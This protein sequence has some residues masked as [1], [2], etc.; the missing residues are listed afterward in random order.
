MAMYI[1]MALAI[2]LGC[3][4]GCGFYTTSTVQPLYTEDTLT[5]EPALVGTWIEVDPVFGEE[6]RPA[7]TFRELAG[8]AYELTVER[9]QERV[10]FEA[11]LVRL[12]KWLYMDLFPQEVAVTPRDH[13][14]NVLCTHAFVRL[15][16]GGDVLR[17]ATLH[18]VAFRTAVEKAKLPHIPVE[19]QARLLLTASTQE[20]QEFML[21]HGDELFC[22][23]P[24]H[25][26][27]K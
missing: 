8:K 23:R 26:R 16:L 24:T 25:Y 4:S 18:L 7:W 21:K 12:G 13:E 19:N 9:N 20:L 17:V 11:H 6:G 14:F 22:G 27:R 15:H 3:L 2:G 10:V 1:R 5:T